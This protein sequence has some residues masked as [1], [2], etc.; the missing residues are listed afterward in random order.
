MSQWGN[1]ASN[2]N[3][4]IQKALYNL[5]YKDLS[6]KLTYTDL[7]TSDVRYDDILQDFATRGQII[8]HPGAATVP[9]SSYNVIDIATNNKR[10]FFGGRNKLIAETLAEAEKYI[11]LK[12]GA[13]Y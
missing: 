13:Q 10:R 8:D 5:N 9:G 12:K 6:S 3:D 7:L 2:L 4:A 1:F 11:D